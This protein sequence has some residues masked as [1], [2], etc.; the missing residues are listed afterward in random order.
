MATI[1]SAA[2]GVWS[3]PATWTPA[4]VPVLGDKVI[5]ANP[6]VVTLDGVY[7]IG[8]DTATALAVNGTLKASRTVD[9]GIK[10][11]GNMTASSTTGKFDFGTEADPIPAEVTVTLTFNDSAVMASSKYLINVNPAS[12]RM[13]GAA[14]K[15]ASAITTLVD[16]SNF[17][18][19][20]ATGWRVG[21]YIFLAATAI[22][23]ATTEARAI[24]AITPGAGTTATITLTAA[25]VNAH[26]VGRVVANVSRNI[27]IGFSQPL[28]FQSMVMVQ[29]PSA[30]AANTFE[31][32]Y[33]EA[34]G[35]RARYDNAGLVLYFANPVAFKK[36]VGISSHD[37]VSISGATVSVIAATGS[38]TLLVLSCVKPSFFDDVVM[39]T[40]NYA[41]GI[42]AVGGGRFRNPT[43]LG[44]GFAIAAHGQMG[45]GSFVDIVNP[46]CVGLAGLLSGAYTG[47]I[48]VTGGVFDGIAGYTISNALNAQ[49]CV[50]QGSSIGVGPLGANA[51]SAIIGNESNASI[52]FDGCTFSANIATLSRA[53]QNW[54]TS[55]GGDL[56]YLTIK[57]KNNNPDYQESVVTSGKRWRENSI[58]LR[59]TSSMRLDP[60]YANRAT[61]YQ[62]S[63]PLA[64]NQTATFMGATRWSA[65]YGASY[66]PSVD[67]TGGGV[68]PVS[69]TNSASADTWQDY[70][71]TVTNPNAYPVTITITYTA[72]TTANTDT[73]FA[74][75]D[76]IYDAP[77]VTSVRHFGYQ[78]L[79]QPYVT[80]DPRI[81]LT[82]A[83][84]LALPVVIDHTAQ[85]ITVTGTATNAEVFQACI[86]DLCQ[87]V[88]QGEAVHISSADGADFTTSYTVTG[89][90]TGVFT[91]PAGRHALISASGIVAGSRVQV[92]DATTAT[93]LYNDIPGT[94][95]AL[96][97]V[98][99]AN[100]ILVLRVAKTG[101]IPVEL[102]GLL[103]ASGANFLV[104]QPVDAVY[105]ALGIDG[106]TCTEFVPDYP[107]LQ[108]DISD[109]DGTTSV[110]RIYAWAAYNQTT[111]LGISSMFGAVTATDTSNFLINSNLVNVKLDNVLPTPVI[112][113][114][115]YLSR[116]DGATVIAATS[117]SIQLD[118]GKAYIAG[119]G[120][121][122]TLAQIEGSSVIAKDATVLTRLA[123]SAYTAPETGI[124]AD[125]VDALMVVTIPVDVAKVH[126]VPVAGTGTE[127]DPW[128]P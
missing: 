95:L 53:A 10:L 63:V 118:P 85:T 37:V 5:I 75:F 80:P 61:E 24:G 88:N 23:A 123:A 108:I 102:A 82:E 40:K 2:S 33:I 56:F 83:A 65:A 122:L 106:S 121:G 39:C 126:G 57:S 43:V 9:N 105:N 16:P 50:F 74:Y 13:W 100:H 25:A 73:A 115:G 125:V 72:K 117:G 94:T 46:T 15:A 71:L 38:T 7:Y 8:D 3:D 31:V 11:R 36:S 112:I 66:P 44:A 21:D 81:T 55:Y 41:N 14:K 87:T 45:A 62:I 124:A 78:F 64:A 17:V 79:A 91:D 89:V 51:T 97:T 114:G 48:R 84:A 107:N 113:T 119:G 127:A 32:G 103:T 96:S 128:G 60:W 111:A 49:N 104:S 93:E 109:G 101:S 19:A 120:A 90:V 20:D 116:S 4:Q 86:A 28:L 27:K 1:T 12:F 59:G 29:M 18:V 34:I 58:D 98:W 110:Q 70:S 69:Y 47:G 77:W 6:H 67:I 30:A 52:A 22:G 99:T 68:T 35:G 92:Y 42:T 26:Y 76:G 54:Q